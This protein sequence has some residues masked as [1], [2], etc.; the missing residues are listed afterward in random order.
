MKNKTALALIQKIQKEVSAKKFS[1][2]LLIELLKELRTISL[3]EKNPV[4]TKALRLAY[5]HLENKNAFYIGIP[6]DEF[7]DNETPSFNFS[8]E[9]DLESL[10]YFIALT[11]DPSKENNLLDLKAYNEAF[12][13]Y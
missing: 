7:S 2:T 5:E 13:A 8:K 4:L 9:N 3:E 12:L 1:C 10:S 11:Q 6:S